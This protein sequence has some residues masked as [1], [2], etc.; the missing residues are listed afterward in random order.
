MKLFIKFLTIIIITTSYSYSE[1]TYN[2]SGIY[3]KIGV[4]DHKHE[5]DMLAINR[6]KITDNTINVNF[7]GDLTQVYDL[8]VLYDSD[9]SFT[10]DNESNL[11][12]RDEY[13]FYLSTGFQKKFNASNGFF[14]V[15]SFSVGL[16]S[17]FDQGKDM[18]SPLEFKSEIEFNFA[19]SSNLIF[20]VTLNH[21]SNADIGSKNPGSDSI[22]VGFK[23]NIN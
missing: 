10:L 17:E 16:Y 19:I 13:A 6:K 23:S 8:M 4:F 9:E 12:N 21:I 14:I 2:N 18:G 5:T 11:K 3:Y 7:L 20:G 15:P 1:Q 22:F